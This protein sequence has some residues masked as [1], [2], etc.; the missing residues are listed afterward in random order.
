MRKLIFTSIIFNFA[1][2]I[3]SNAIEYFQ[4]DVRYT[5]QVA[6]DDRSHILRASEVI[7]YKNNSNT[8]LKELYFHLW[9]A[10]YESKN[11]IL[12]QEIFKSGDDRMNSAKDKNLGKIDSLD[13]KIN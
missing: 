6:L 1:I 3:H 13:F 7:V 10:A 12:A 2:I 8:A 9:P 4:Q 11:T 5:I